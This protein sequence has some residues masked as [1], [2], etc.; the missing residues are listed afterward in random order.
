MSEIH[1]TEIE[2]N[3]ALC[4]FCNAADDEWTPSKWAEETRRNFVRLCKA[5]NDWYVFM[6]ETGRD[7]FARSLSNGER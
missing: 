4:N 1:P 6:K 5:Y 7:P 2:L 3:K